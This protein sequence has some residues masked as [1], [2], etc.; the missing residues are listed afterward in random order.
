MFGLFRKL[1]KR[2]L[3]QRLLKEGQLN[4]YISK[5]H[6]RIQDLEKKRQKYIDMAHQGKV[7]QD[8]GQMKLGIKYTQYV[9]SNLTKMRGLKARLEAANLMLDSQDAYNEM[10][11]AV[12]EF[13]GEMKDGSVRKGKQRRILRRWKKETGTLSSQIR[14]IDSRLDKIDNNMEKVFQDNQDYSDV[15][16]DEFFSKYPS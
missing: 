5:F 3:K 12:S 10:V 2:K 16:V 8:E 4:A 7:N 14:M 13:T 1:R 6:S 15:N 9:D 11:L